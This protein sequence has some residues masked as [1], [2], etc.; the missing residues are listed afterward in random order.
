MTAPNAYTVTRAHDT[1]ENARDTDWRHEAACFGIATRE[2]D[3]WYATGKTAAAEYNVARRV[4]AGCPVRQM[5]LEDALTIE[6]T[7]PEADVHG[8][9]GGLTPNERIALLHGKR[10]PLMCGD[11]QGTDAGWQRH[12]RRAQDPCPECQQAHSDT[13]KNYPDSKDARIRALAAEG[14]TQVDIARQLRVSRNTVRRV[15][16]ER[17]AS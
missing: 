11:K 5:C 7:G 14:K 4:C 13:A 10:R 17:V 16:A 9:R 15:L 1:R 6:R 2:Y 3:P 8:V 12:R